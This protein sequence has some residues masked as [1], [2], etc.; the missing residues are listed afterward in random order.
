MDHHD[1]IALLSGGVL[2]GGTSVPP[3]GV[4]ADLGS[5]GGAFTLALAELLGPAGEIYSVDRDQGALREQER[6]LR[7]RFPQVTLHHLVADF[8]RQLPLP[9]LD[10]V[11]MANSLHFQRAKAPVLTLV[12]SYLKLG[13]RLI[14]VEYNVDHGNMWVPHPFSYHSWER[15]AAEAGFTGTRLLAT[16]PSHFLDEIYSAV[17]YKPEQAAA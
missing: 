5:G 4:W 7:A 14:V 13:G 15:L 16:R 17:C 2:V 11:V 10:G 8:S 3:G 12:G 9:P 6:S 1:H